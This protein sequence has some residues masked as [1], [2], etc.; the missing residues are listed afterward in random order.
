MRDSTSK[1]EFVLALVL[2]AVIHVALFFVAAVAVAYDVLLGKTEVK[3][4][5][6]EKKKEVTP[7]QVVYEEEFIPVPEMVTVPEETMAP[8]PEPELAEKDPEPAFVQTREDQATEEVPEDSNLIGE[9]STKATSD[10]GAEAGDEA[11]AA[12]AGEEERRSDPKT[13]DSNFTKGEDSG[14]TDGSQEAFETG[15]GNDQINQKMVESVTPDPA[16]IV[17]DRPAVEETMP[18]PEPKKVELPTVENALAALE[19]ELAEPKE[20]IPDGP[21]SEKTEEN[22]PQRP[23]SEERQAANQDGG[24]APRARKTRIAGVISARG[25]GSLDV[26]NT[27]VGRYQAGIFKKLETAWQM[28]NISNRSLLAPGTITLYFTVGKTG[29]VAGQKQVSMNGASGTQWGMIL[30]ALNG[31]KIPE[32]PDKVVDE[33]EGDP[34]EII[35]TFNY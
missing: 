11:M 17:D 5:P 30:R 34:L 26:E 14:A 4:K 25:S 1:G 20:E 31:L 18:E 10:E 32:M 19:E 23:A 28:E 15:Q 35:V 33:L 27:A 8:E 3:E 9:R 12:L 2:A 24:F 21:E 13:F 6:I 16:E 29:Q 7:V 22:L